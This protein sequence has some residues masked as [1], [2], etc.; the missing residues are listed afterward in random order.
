MRG[1]SLKAL[2]FILTVLVGQSHAADTVLPQKHAKLI[3]KVTQGKQLWYFGGW[4]PPDSFTDGA[5][6]VTLVA[7]G[8]TQGTFKWDITQGSSKALFDGDIASVTKTDDNSV[9]LKA[10]GLSAGKGDV[11]VRLTFGTQ[12]ATRKIEVRGPKLLE[13]AGF[14]DSEAGDPCTT[15]GTAGWRSGIIYNIRNQ[16]G[17]LVKNAGLNEVIGSQVAVESPN[18]WPPGAPYQTAA[19]AGQFFDLLC[20]S[21]PFTPTPQVPGST[22]STRL[23]D[24]IAQTWYS[25]SLLTGGGVKIQTNNAYR[26]IDHGRHADIVSP[27]P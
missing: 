17:E 20:V 27:V 15:N 6:D 7:S 14:A 5:T 21:G 26:Y 25:G 1:T 23:I 9:L 24:K 22:L 12:T 16:F 8:K 19:E 13:P 11:W 2:F 18:N 4:T 3:I 10:K